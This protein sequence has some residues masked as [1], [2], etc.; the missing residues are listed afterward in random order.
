MS[1][2]GQPSCMTD[3]PDAGLRDKRDLARSQNKLVL[4]LVALCAQVVFSE[5]PIC[6]WVTVTT[7]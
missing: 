6:E 1:Q 5:T 7:S 2:A 4:F 3:M